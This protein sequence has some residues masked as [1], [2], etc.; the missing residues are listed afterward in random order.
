MVTFFFMAMVRIATA[1]PGVEKVSTENVAYS[2]RAFFHKQ[3]PY[4]GCSLRLRRLRPLNW[5]LSGAD[6]EAA[7]E[8]GLPFAEVGSTMIQ[9]SNRNSRPHLRGSHL[10]CL[11][12]V[13][14]AGSL[15]DYWTD[16]GRLLT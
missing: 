4:V 1:E 15:L 10:T 7:S 3:A 13:A 12:Q 11:R 14:A 5:E 6:L 9:V 8:V 2:P 16:F